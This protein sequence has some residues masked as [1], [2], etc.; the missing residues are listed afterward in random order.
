MADGAWGDI[1][2]SSNQV[3]ILDFPSI[4][5]SSTTMEQVGIVEGLGHP[6]E[7][8][9]A[10]RFIGDVGFIVTFRRTDPFYTIDVSDPKNP[11]V[12]GELNVTGFSSYLHP[13][14]DNNDYLLAIGQEADPKTGRQ[15]GL[16]I[17]VFDVRDLSQPQEVTKYLVEQSDK[18]SSSS[19]S[20]WEYKSFRY[21]KE[22]NILIL[23]ASVYE[24]NVNF[25]GFLVF[26]AKV[27]A[28]TPILPF[29]SKHGV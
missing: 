16:K 1:S 13:M 5:S 23:P 6:E 11:F 12:V 14:D 27:D 21:L 10:V 18:G 8:I 9:H 25:D 28:I 20:Q 17:S 22:S 7:S 4:G 3:I 19:E 2:D 15:V 24:W 29:T 26:D